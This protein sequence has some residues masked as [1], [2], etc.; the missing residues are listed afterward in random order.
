MKKVFLDLIKIKKIKMNK[1]Y[2]K[3]WINL[4]IEDLKVSQILYENKKYSNSFYHF[5]QA[6]E[7][8]LKAYAFMCKTYTSE[9]EANNTG[10]YTLKLC[11]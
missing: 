6:S 11:V 2:I 7:K 10:H 5:Q 8:G 9:K 3:S 4:S 1:T